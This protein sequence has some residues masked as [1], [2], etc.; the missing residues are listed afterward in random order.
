LGTD[1]A[2]GSRGGARGGGWG[3]VDI[4]IDNMGEAGNR[5]GSSLAVFFSSFSQQTSVLSST[6]QAKSSVL[7][8]GAPQWRQQ[9]A[10]YSLALPD[11]GCL[12]VFKRS[13]VLVL[14]I[15][16]YSY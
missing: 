9:R 6:I 1:G 15:L 5:F 3:L 14:H 13:C 11:S 8:V 2:D 12:Q 10:E 16:I 4:L 7:V